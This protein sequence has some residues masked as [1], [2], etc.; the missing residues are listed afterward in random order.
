MLAA[1]PVGWLAAG[2]VR[3]SD[4]MMALLELVHQNGWL[5]RRLLGRLFAHS[6]L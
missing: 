6:S 2:N 4:W 1:L 3:L 5:G